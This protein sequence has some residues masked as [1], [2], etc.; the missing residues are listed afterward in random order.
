MS[1]RPETDSRWRAPGAEIPVGLTIFDT[2]LRFVE[3][4]AEMGAAPVSK[5]APPGDLPNT[6]H[7]GSGVALGHSASE[8]L[9]A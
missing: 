5:T 1:A 7:V 8:V 4:D 9:G 3:V 2:A 6:D